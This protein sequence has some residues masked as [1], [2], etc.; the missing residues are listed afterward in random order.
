MN[1]TLL[2]ACGCVF[3]IRT[4]AYA[5]PP[6][7][8]LSTDQKIVTLNS[9]AAAFTP[10]SARS[11]LTPIFENLAT[12]DPKGVYM[13]GTGYAIGGP[14][15]AI[16]QAWYASAFT[17]AANATASEVDVAA[18]FI[19]GTKAT[20]TVHI[21]ADAA[22][23]PGKELW[24][25]NASLPT[26]GGC[27]ALVAVQVKGGVPLTAGTQYWVG[28]TTLGTSEDTFASWFFNVADQVDT[29]TAAE[30]QG[31]GWYPQPLLPN[32]AFGVYSK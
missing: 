5:A 14:N 20:L 25:H 27:C 4:I 19:E 3:A 24:A 21:Y 31:S 15:S 30:N 8:T 23:L 1:R 17:P 18:G 6:A 2:L 26:A 12:L 13:A 16:G 10:F 32:V 9:A 22:G 29:G 7:F 11:G 28:L